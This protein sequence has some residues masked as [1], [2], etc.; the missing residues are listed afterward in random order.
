MVGMPHGRCLPFSK[1]WRVVEEISNTFKG[2][3][4]L[5]AWFII[6][7]SLE[8]LN[9]DILLYVL[10]YAD[11]ESLLSLAQLLSTLR[12]LI[13]RFFLSCWREELSTFFLPPTETRMWMRHLNIVVSGSSA[14]CQ[15]LPNTMQWQNSDLDIYCP[16]KN[17]VPCLEYLF[18]QGYDVIWSEELSPPNDP[19]PYLP[20]HGPGI[21]AVIR[22]QHP[23]QKKINVIISI[24]DNALLPIT[25]FWG[26]IVQ[27]YIAAD[28]FTIAYP[29]TTLNGIGYIAPERAQLTKTLECVE[30]YH[31]RGFII[32]QYD[33][34]N[35]HPYCPAHLRSFDDHC[36]LRFSFTEH[37][38]YFRQH[39]H[40]WRLN[41]HCHCETY[42]ANFCDV[43][44]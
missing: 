32:L 16:Q 6:T 17:A 42:V 34:I 27:N 21:F 12:C 5:I 40:Y 30:K 13:K 7:T 1:Q 24:T 26:S 19:F 43:F 29:H 39:L 10:S 4:P 18:K 2:I 23:G 36:T 28:S 20:Y 41:L 3:R 31:A 8:H 9:H 38:N 11:T 37:L 14:L 44:A 33:C 35:H 25:S 15:V 22:L